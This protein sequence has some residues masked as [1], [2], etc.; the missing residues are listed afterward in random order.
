MWNTFLVGF[1]RRPFFLFR[2][3]E[4]EL[5]VGSLLKLWRVG[6]HCLVECDIIKCD[7]VSLYLRI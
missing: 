5:V 1:Q 7:T 4:S 6:L 3:G 2:F